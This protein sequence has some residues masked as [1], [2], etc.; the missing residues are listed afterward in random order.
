[1]LQRHTVNFT[2]DFHW[3]VHDDGHIRSAMQLADI[4]SP[5]TASQRTRTVQAVDCTDEKTE[6]LI[7]RLIDELFYTVYA[8]H[9]TRSSRHRHRAI[10]LCL[11]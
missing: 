5:Q 1:M 8:L 9:K 7:G 10:E 4:A 6:T 11:S 2:C 3:P